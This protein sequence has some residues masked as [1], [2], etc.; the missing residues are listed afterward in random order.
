MSFVYM[1]GFGV[2]FAVGAYVGAQVTEL[3]CGVAKKVVGRY[4]HIG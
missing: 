2:C 1:F 4:I 3:A